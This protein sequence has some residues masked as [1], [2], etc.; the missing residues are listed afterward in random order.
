M[1]VGVDLNA[2]HPAGRVRKQADLY[3]RANP[4]LNGRRHRAALIEQLL[5][6]RP[7]PQQI[8]S[9]VYFTEF[10]RQMLTAQEPERAGEHNKRE[11]TTYAS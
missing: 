6:T 4:R 5:I 9:Q 10:R 8:T 3:P 1:A 7:T 11:E 2:E